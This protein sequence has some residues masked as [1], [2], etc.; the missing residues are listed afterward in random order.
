MGDVSTFAD[1]EQRLSKP[2]AQNQ[3]RE[4][5][6]R[7]GYC[8]GFIAAVNGIMDSWFLGRRESYDF[9]YDHWRDALSDW[10]RE[11]AFDGATEWLPP[12]AAPKCAYCGAPAE[13]IDHV[14]PRSQGG[15][16]DPRNLVPA[17]AKCNLT[18]GAR[19][20]EEAGM[21]FIDA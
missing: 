3:I 7:R 21:E 20:P 9:L 17:C 6:Y 12:S 5:E 8:D 2:E 14:I 16:D 10:R 4:R 13:H 19:T 15:T 1:L 18:K 11:I